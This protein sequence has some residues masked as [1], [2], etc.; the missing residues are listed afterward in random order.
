MTKGDIVT[1]R[2]KCRD[3]EGDIRRETDK[4]RWREIGIES[5][6]EESHR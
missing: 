2:Q 6:V 1:N 3:K 5:K 4:E